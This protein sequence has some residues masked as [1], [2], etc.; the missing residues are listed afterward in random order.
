M[1][2]VNGR[3][4]LT[5]SNL[6]N[7]DYGAERN[8]SGFGFDLGFLYVVQENDESYKWRFGASILDIGSIRFDKNAQTHVVN[9]PNT[10]QLN[11]R[12]FD[13]FELPGEGEALLLHFSEQ[14]LGNPTA[15]LRGDN[16]KMA[17]P[18]AISMQADYNVND[19]LF[20]N[21]LLVHPVPIGPVSPG[22]QPLLAFTPRFEHRWFS[23]SIPVSLLNWRKTNLGLAA[24]LGFL[25]IGSDNIGSIFGK[26]DY[27]GTDIYAA[28]KLNPFDL[29]WG[30]FKGRGV[31]NG[32][33]RRGS[34]KK[35]RCYNF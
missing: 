17:L 6:K 3:Y 33:E 1:G 15:S 16:F 20:L 24:R 18:T 19:Q 14:A 12:D 2:G 25:V 26:S 31:G 11:L 13:D 27:S 8:G 10:F 5:T 35:V 29:G 22:R 30:L 34:K 9:N 32:K 28:L 21:G 7:N 4:G 23:A